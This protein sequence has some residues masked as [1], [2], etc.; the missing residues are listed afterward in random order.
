MY[1]RIFENNI[2]FNVSSEY[3][4]IAGN[5]IHIKVTALHPAR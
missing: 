4:S 1:E 5:V 3:F 2:V